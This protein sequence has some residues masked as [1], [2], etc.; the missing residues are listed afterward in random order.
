VTAEFTNITFGTQE[1]IA[2]I[3][4]NR[5]EALNAFTR[6]MG[7]EVGEA[8]E[9]CARDDT[10][11]V[12]IFTGEGRAFSAGADIKEERPRT[13][14]GQSDLG[15]GLRQTYNPLILA[16]RRLP[17]PVIAAVNGPA[18]GFSCSLACACDF[19][20]AAES[21]YFLLAFVRIGLVPDGGASMTLPARIGIGRA[22]ELAMLGDRVAS[23]QA[24]LWGLVNQ[25]CPDEELEIRVAALASRLAAGPAG[26]Y[27]EIKALFNSAHLAGLEAQLGAEAAAQYRRGT[28]SE[29]AEGARAFVE[30]RP[31]AF[32]PSTSQ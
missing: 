12:V 32:A 4:F 28:T 21:A 5:P 26:A 8:L 25:V 30:K 13:P 24:H 3:G 31:A 6:V 15:A 7:T 16:I 10:V 27:G 17:K 14:E 1:G 2:R 9:R 11:R 20:L 29:Y 22:T 23:R 18:V 19:I